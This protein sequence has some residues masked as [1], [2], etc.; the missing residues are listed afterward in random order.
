MKTNKH[1][2]GC[3]SI[4]T[5]ERRCGMLLKDPAA[6]DLGQCPCTK[7]LVK[8]MCVCGCPDYIDFK[9]GIRRRAWIHL[10]GTMEVRDK[11]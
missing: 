3:P 6:N 11:T 1:C 5:T 8:V 9:L 4:S 10:P 7:C 2:K